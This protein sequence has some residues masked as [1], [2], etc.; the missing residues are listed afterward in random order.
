METVYITPV[1]PACAELTEKRSKFIANI[2]SVS[3]EQDALDF[4]KEI[5]KKYYD[6]KHNVFAYITEGIKR[7]NDDGEP[8][9]TGGFPVLEMLDNQNITDVVCV[10]TRYF[11]GVL[12]G[13]GGLV[14][15]YGSAAKLALEAAGIKE[16]T[17]HDELLISVPYSLFESIKHLAGK[18]NCE[19]EDCEYSDSV[20]VRAVCP[21][22][23]TS[24]FKN[25]ISGAFGLNIDVEDINK[26]YR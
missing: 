22:E 2:K 26:V 10:V 21:C 5:K 25:S 1:K 9:K 19:F 12:L 20:K 6:A 8:S 15:A 23:N 11:G 14:R 7:Y 17:L 13:T 3:S 16:M 4:I 18:F 24:D